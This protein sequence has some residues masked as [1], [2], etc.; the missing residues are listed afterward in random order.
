MPCAP[1]HTQPAVLLN[2]NARG[3]GPSTAKL[4]G[5]ALPEAEVFL[6]KSLSDAQELAKKIL[7]VSYNPVLLGGGDGTL[8]GFLEA[9]LQASRQLKQP[10]PELG[11]LRLGT[12]N[13]IA[14]WT[15]LHGG[16]R[17]LLGALRHMSEAHQRKHKSLNLIEFNNRLAPFAGAGLD[18]KVLGD[19]VRFKERAAQKPW[20]RLA[21][22]LKGYVASVALHTL[23]YYWRHSTQIQ[24]QVRNVGARAHR[25][26]PDGSLGPSLEKGAVLY[27]GAATMVAASTIPLYGYGI[28]MFPFAERLPRCM[29]LR[30]LN[31]NSIPRLLWNLPSWWRGRWFPQGMHDFVLEEVSVSCE[32]PMPCQAGGDTAGEH[33]SMHLKLSEV[34][35]PLVDFGAL[36]I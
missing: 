1:L 30:V 13:A 23:P 9:L 24:C 21:G 28:R 35:V 3:V 5:Q 33:D 25:V 29:H 34:C 22:G 8:M 10:L 18:G 12:G 7:I 16:K 17:A 19:Y 36:A 2:A 6:S 4:I 15:G 11:L 27:E 20:R 31:L 32:K 14:R 26:H